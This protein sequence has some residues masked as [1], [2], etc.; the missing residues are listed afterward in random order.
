M[1]TQVADGSIDKSVE[2]D[3]YQSPAPVPIV[4]ESPLESYPG[5]GSRPIAV[6]ADDGPSR[7]SGPRCDT[8]NDGCVV[9]DEISEQIGVL[10]PAIVGVI[11]SL[12]V[13]GH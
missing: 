2:Q 11:A 12:V 1:I 4:R 10:H 3:G 6:L 5:N 9:G 13:L 7:E 8:D